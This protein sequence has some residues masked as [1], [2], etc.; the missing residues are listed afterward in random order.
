MRLLYVLGKY[1]GET[2]NTEL[3]LTTLSSSTSSE[4]NRTS[5]TNP[6]SLPSLP[7]RHD[8]SEDLEL[9]EEAEVYPPPSGLDGSEEDASSDSSI[10]RPALLSKT[11][12]SLPLPGSISAKGS[13]SQPHIANSARKDDDRPSK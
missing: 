5:R 1:L 9:L 2:E 7:Q 10:S 12:L 8:E 4:S 13:E 3:A 6:C 11:V